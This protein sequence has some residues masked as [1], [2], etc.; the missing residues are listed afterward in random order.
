MNKM[1][2]KALTDLCTV[3]LVL[4]FTYAACS[5][6]IDYDQSKLQMAKQLLP[7]GAAPVLTWLVPAIELLIAGLLLFNNTRLPGLYASAILMAM[8]SLYIGIAMSG[9]FGARPCSCGGILHYLNYWQHLLFNLAFVG[10]AVLGVKWEQNLKRKEVTG[11][12]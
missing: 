6:L 5:K 12:N 11:L 8:F 3:L 2:Y 4:L 9:W 1:K 10:V 7:A